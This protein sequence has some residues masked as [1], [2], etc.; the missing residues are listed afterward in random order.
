MAFRRDAA[1]LLE[2][3]VVVFVVAMVAGQLLG[4]PVLLGFVTTDSMRPTLEARALRWVARVL[5]GTDV[6]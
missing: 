1:A 3:A 2:G 5:S 4:Q 6:W